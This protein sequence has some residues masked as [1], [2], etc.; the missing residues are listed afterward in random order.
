MSDK[1]NTWLIVPMYHV[2]TPEFR[3]PH[4]TACIAYSGPEQRRYATFRFTD[5]DARPS[6][7]VRDTGPRIVVA[8]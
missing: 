3:A 7:S 5:D 6:R 1:Q 4:G 2:P 8:A